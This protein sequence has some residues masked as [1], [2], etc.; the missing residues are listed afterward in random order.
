MHGYI[1]LAQGLIF[2]LIGYVIGCLFRAAIN[3][4]VR[5]WSK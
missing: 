3:L 2:V 4:G 5:A 1:W